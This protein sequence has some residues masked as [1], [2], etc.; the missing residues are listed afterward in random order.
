MSLPKH[1]ELLHIVK[2]CKRQTMQIEDAAASLKVPDFVIPMLVKKND[3]L[4]IQGNLIVAKRDS[5]GQGIFI[6]LTFISIIII[7][8]FFGE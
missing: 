6:L 2:A 8:G 1:I 3:D 7:T 4:S 5:T